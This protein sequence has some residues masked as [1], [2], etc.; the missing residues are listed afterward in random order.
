MA[1][2]RTN[3]FRIRGLNADCDKLACQSSVQ[4]TWLVGRHR[5]LSKGTE[6]AITKDEL[7]VLRPY[8]GAPVVEITPLGGP[9]GVLILELARGGRM[10]VR[11]GTKQRVEMGL[12][13]ALVIKTEH[14]K[15]PQGPGADFRA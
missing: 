11:N 9:H 15:P 8:G 1:E 3:G 10:A 13:E 5:F 14:W 6:V 2:D 7:I 12:D 4:T